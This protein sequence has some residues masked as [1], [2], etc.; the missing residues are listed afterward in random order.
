MMTLRA[1]ID[2]TSIALPRTAMPAGH[3]ETFKGWL[4]IASEDEIMEIF[5]VT[6]WP[7]ESVSKV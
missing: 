1:A 7:R 3:A 5:R 4:K 6:H 2:N